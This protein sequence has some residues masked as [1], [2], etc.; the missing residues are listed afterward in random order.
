MGVKEKRFETK[1]RKTN[2]IKSVKAKIREKLGRGKNRQW[3]LKKKGLKQKGVK[4]TT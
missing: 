3:V 4:Q 1:G 2:Y